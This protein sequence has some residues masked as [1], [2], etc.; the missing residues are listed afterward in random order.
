[1]EVILITIGYNC[2][3]NHK[4]ILTNPYLFIVM[5]VLCVCV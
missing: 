4:K 1:M 5:C 3:G 2:Q